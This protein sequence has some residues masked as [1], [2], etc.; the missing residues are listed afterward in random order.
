MSDTEARLARL[1]Q[2]V[3]HLEDHVAIL[4]VINRYGP[5]VDSGSAEQVAALWDAEGVYDYAAE[6]PSLEGG[7]AIAAMVRS[8]PHQGYLRGGCGH[9][10]GP[11]LVHVEGDRAVATCYSLLVRHDEAAD[12][13]RV[14]RL[15]ANRW[16]LRRD[17]AQWRVTRRTNRLL[18][19]RAQGRELLGLVA[20][21]EA[22]GDPAREGDEG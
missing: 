21:T 3:H 2:R 11:P 15:S 16:E 12:G 17:G 7:D 18:D 6:V 8:G 1:E 14:A 9:V 20:E 5:L 13:Y 4:Q 19:G 22:A 10:I